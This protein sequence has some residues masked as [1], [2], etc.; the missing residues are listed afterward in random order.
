MPSLIA[1]IFSSELRRIRSR[2]IKKI[3]RGE[4]DISFLEDENREDLECFQYN[5]PH[6][7]LEPIYEVD[8]DYF[9]GFQGESREILKGWISL[10]YDLFISR[11][12]GHPWEVCHKCGGRMHKSVYLCNTHPKIKM[13]QV[14]KCQH[15]ECGHEY[16]KAPFERY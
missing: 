16:V 3:E 10:R 7:N 2:L 9:N 6:E 15:R 12:E 1:K 5:C 14:Y 11:P 4:G 8:N 13:G